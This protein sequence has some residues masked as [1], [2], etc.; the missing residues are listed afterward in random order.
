[1]PRAKIAAMLR[2]RISTGSSVSPVSVWGTF[3]RK[4]TAS[5]RAVR[6]SGC[7]RV[8][9]PFLSYAMPANRR[10]SPEKARFL[11]PS[12]SPSRDRRKKRFPSESDIES[13]SGRLPEIAI[14]QRVARVSLSRPAKTGP[15]TVFSPLA[16]L[17]SESERKRQN[18]RKQ[19]KKPTICEMQNVGFCCLPLAVR[20]L[21]KQRSCGGRIRTD[22]LEVM[23]LASYRAAPPRV[24]LFFH[25]SLAATH[26]CG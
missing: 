5:P 23:S 7:K 16:R 11:K 4:M 6:E 22:D 8:A 3:N 14:T 24:V 10:P 17:D 20:F 1:M 9:P 21:T 25:D 18:A 15:K 26:S 12:V 19:R 2:N 13:P